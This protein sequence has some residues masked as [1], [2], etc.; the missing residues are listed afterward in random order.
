MRPDGL[1]HVV[2]YPD[3]THH[4]D[5]A[6]MLVA[7]ALAEVAEPM[8]EH[9]AQVWALFTFSAADLFGGHD[10]SSVK[11]QWYPLWLEERKC[12]ERILSKWE[13]GDRH[14][15]SMKAFDNLCEQSW[16]HYKPE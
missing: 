10:D 9:F 5:P 13:W 6:N 1:P 12:M 11:K 7:A 8:P 3:G 15:A 2:T 4:M 16:N 14:V